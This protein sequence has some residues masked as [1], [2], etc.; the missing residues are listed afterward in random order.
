MTI[1]LKDLTFSYSRK[2]APAIDG[3]S[4]E[5][6]P[7]LHLLMGEN[8]AGKTT[9][10]HLI[11]GLQSPTSG[12]CEINGCP[13][14]LR[15][16]SVNSEIFFT[17]VNLELP[18]VTVGEMAR[19][20]G[21]FYPRFSPD[22]LKRNLDAFGLDANMK[23][24]SLSTGS[25]QKAKIAYALALHTGILLLDEPANGLDIEAKRTFNSLIASQVDSG[26]TV[27]VSTHNVVELERM[28]DGV[29]DMSHGRLLYAGTIDEITSRVCFSQCTVPPSDAIYAEPAI[30]RFKCI[31]HNTDGSYS[32]PDYQML[33]MA[34]RN[35][36]SAAAIIDLLNMPYYE[37]R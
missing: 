13:T 20:H 21:Q 17:G 26:Q 11:A 7:G 25:Y 29:I 33:Y 22:D 10:L 3:I 15:L 32:E 2:G 23:L 36:R 9:L 16:P 5:I 1:K 14:R 31:L 8:G 6:N 24:R 18:A 34:S 35:P 28:F 30:D 27:I 12:V 4:C 19:I 37:K